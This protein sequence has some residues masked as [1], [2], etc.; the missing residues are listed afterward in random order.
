MPLAKMVRR[1]AL[2]ARTI[3]QIIEGF[4]TFAPTYPYYL[5]ELGA[6]TDEVRSSDEGQLAMEAMLRVIERN[7]DVDLG[8]PG[9]LV[10]T[11]ETF[12]RKGYEKKLLESLARKPTDLTV[13]ML[14][15][16]VN[17]AEGQTKESYLDLL[18][19]IAQNNAKDEA[20]RNSAKHFLEYQAGG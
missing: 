5:E 4:N 14:N 13:W 7:P 15:R 6:L 11:L 10:H 17:G 12:Y 1:K 2:M 8:S 20:A 19:E 3:Q 16:L 18:T 9:P